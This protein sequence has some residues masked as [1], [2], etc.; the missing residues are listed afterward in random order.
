MT[1]LEELVYKGAMSP[2][3]LEVMTKAMSILDSL[4]VED[5]KA[6]LTEVTLNTY[7]GE[8]ITQNVFAILEDELVTIL[9]LMGLESHEPSLTL[10][11]DILD[12]LS[13]L[14]TLDEDLLSGLKEQAQGADTHAEVLNITLLPLMKSTTSEFEFIVGTIGDD[15]IA[16]IERMLGRRDYLDIKSIVVSNHIR[17]WLVKR[18][19]LNSEEAVQ[20]SDLAETYLDLPLSKIVE[21]YKGKM[22]VTDIVAL[23]LLSKD[24]R[25]APMSSI[26]REFASLADAHG[27]EIEAA[28]AI[29]GEYNG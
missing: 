17:E 10:L 29:A 26:R 8:D 5:Y 21:L 7:E 15:F 14:H 18:F 13:S 3:P 28:I 1:L 24:G 6:R 4:G 11:V 12:A 23:A 20:V 22:S 2:L 9:R 25:V 19:N 16:L 27:R